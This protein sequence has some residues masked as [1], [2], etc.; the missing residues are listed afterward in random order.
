[1]ETI[2][3]YLEAMFANL[4]NTAEV[5]KAK[6]ELLNMM[7]D[8]YNE[9]IS[10]GQSENSAV[11]TVISEFGNLDELA[12]DLGLTKEVEET[13]EREAKVSRRFLRNEEVL[14]YLNDKRNSGMMIGIGVMLCII[15]VCFPILGSLVFHEGAEIYS[16]AGMFI[17]IGVAIALFVFNGIRLSEWSFLEKEPC[18][19]DMQTAQQVREKRKTFKTTYALMIALGVMLCAMCWLPIAVMQTEIYV[20]SIFVMVGIGVFL[21]IYSNSV[22]DSYDTILKLNDSETISGNYGKENEMEYINKPAQAMMEVYWPTIVCLYLIISFITF[23]WGI[24]WIIWPI[25]GI[26]NKILRIALTKEA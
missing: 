11:G 1:M 16:V 25:A 26:L 15:S 24:T 19:V 23:E 9:L 22:M 14:D 13:R 10:E 5:K 20:S 12:E 18:Q 7:E 4:P 21:F 8:K 6:A 2:K 3:N 17:C